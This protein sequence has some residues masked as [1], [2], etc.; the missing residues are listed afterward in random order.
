MA[1]KILWDNPKKK[2]GADI[3]PAP[4]PVEPKA[5]E[6]PQE[7]PRRNYPPAA[8]RYYSEYDDQRRQERYPDKFYP[9]LQDAL[10]Y[11]ANLVKDRETGG[12]KKRHWLHC[13]ATGKA[14]TSNRGHMLEVEDPRARHGRDNLRRLNLS[15][16]TGTIRLLDGLVREYKDGSKIS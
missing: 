8:Q 3:A 5:T 12:L 4:V 16:F 6:E 1:R 14:Y 9:E 11:G 15:T 7:P 2:A 10:V 13:R